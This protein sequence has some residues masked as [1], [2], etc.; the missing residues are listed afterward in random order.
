MNQEK[1]QALTLKWQNWTNVCLSCMIV[2]VRVVFKKTVIGNWH[3]DYSTWAVF[4]F[5][6]KWRVS[7]IAF[8]HLVMVW[9]NQF[10]CDVIDHQNVKVAVIAQL[11]MFCCYFPFTM[12]NLPCIMSANVSDICQ[13]GI[14]ICIGYKHIWVLQPV[15][16]C[17]QT[18]LNLQLCFQSDFP[19][20]FMWSTSGAQGL[21]NIHVHV[22]L[23]IEM[24]FAIFL[25]G[26]SNQ[27]HQT[28][29]SLQ[30]HQ[31]S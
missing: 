22:A 29:P 30:E 27:L 31:S 15:A 21:H 28:F 3:F 11:L 12:D 9:I 6:V 14:S 8:M 26:P 24:P 13:S 25:Q 16:K 5:R 1:H 18:E 2:R 4:I 20:Y 23:C 19:G 17:L 7:L 10:G